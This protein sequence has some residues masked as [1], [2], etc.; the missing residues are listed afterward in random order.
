MT[1]ALLDRPVSAR[2]PALDGGGTLEE[3]LGSVLEQARANG[4]TE[5]PVCHDRMS[6]ARARESGAAA[7]S[8]ECGGCGSRL[9]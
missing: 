3:L 5:C 9:A 2:R 4:G 1:G 8:A 6:F 7:A